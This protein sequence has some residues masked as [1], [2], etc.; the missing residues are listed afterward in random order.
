MSEIA[1]E[2]RLVTRIG[3]IG[4]IHAEDGSLEI[5]LRFLHG[6]QLDAILAVGD[7]ADGYGDLNRSCKL[8]EQYQVLAVRGNHERWFLNNQMRDLPDI[9]PAETVSEKTRCY[10]AALP[11]TMSFETPAG[12]LLLCHGLDEYDMGGLR[13]DGRFLDFCSIEELKKILRSGAHR[14]MLNGHTHERM[15][16]TVEYLTIINA[17]TIR[18]SRVPC[19]LMTDFAAGFVQFYEIID[20]QDVIAAERIAFS[21]KF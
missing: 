19:F 18:S 9:N 15:V 12:H 6:Q 8:L 21:T 3:A 20:G 16:C 4:D 5:A 17:G 10:L 13:P 2:K 1:T 11:V 14:F 7:I